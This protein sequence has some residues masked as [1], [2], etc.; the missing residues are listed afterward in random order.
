MPLRANQDGVHGNWVMPDDS[1]AT[2]ASCSASLLWV[3]SKSSKWMGF[4][5][6][7]KKKTRIFGHFC[8]KIWTLGRPPGPPTVAY[9]A[10]LSSDVTQP[11]RMPPWIALSGVRP[12]HWNKY[13]SYTKKHH[14]ND[15]GLKHFFP[16]YLEKCNHLTVWNMPKSQKG[17]GRHSRGPPNSKNAAPNSINAK[18]RTREPW[19]A[20]ARHHGDEFQ[21][22]NRQRHLQSIIQG[23]AGPRFQTL[24][25]HNFLMAPVEKLPS[26][27]RYLLAETFRKWYGLTIFVSMEY[28]PLPFSRP[29]EYVPNILCICCNF[30]Y[31]FII[32]GIMI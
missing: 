10:A 24:R 23:E 1:V 25:R 26:G 32:Q 13:I 6:G 16:T 9:V 11:P 22:C 19:T 2:F 28:A 31:I 5:H 12:S 8:G 4:P 17:Y 21:K 30:I 7:L 29:L 18:T 27:N 14:E 20:M 15:E 3:A